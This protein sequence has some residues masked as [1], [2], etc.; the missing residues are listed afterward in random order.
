MLDSRRYEKTCG[1][2][3]WRGRGK[4]LFKLVEHLE[5]ECLTLLPDVD[6]LLNLLL[7]NE[8]K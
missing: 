2:L 3:T 4:F 1:I 7:Q 5:R 8:Y 6:E